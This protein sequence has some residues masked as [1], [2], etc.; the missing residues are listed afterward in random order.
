MAWEREF[1]HV[2]LAEGEHVI[3]L[4]DRTVKMRGGK[5]ARW[6]IQI[7]LGGEAFS[8]Q[9]GNKK[10]AIRLGEGLTPQA[11]GTLKDADGNLFDPEDFTRQMVAQL[12]EHHQR[13][14]A[15]ARRQRAPLY[16]GTEKRT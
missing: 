7:K 1:H 14:R 15:Y 16:D 4:I 13:R 12:E 3:S 5:P 9:I 8:Y 10:L 11:D 6:L 2:D